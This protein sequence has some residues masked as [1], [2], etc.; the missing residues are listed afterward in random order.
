MKYLKIYLHNYFLI[1]L[2]LSVFAFFFM[3]FYQIYTFFIILFLIWY[4]YFL[5][6]KKKLTIDI[7]H[8]NY[9]IFIAISIM[10]LLASF[11][12]ILYKSFLD[13]TLYHPS[14]FC[15]TIFLFS[16]FWS[17]HRSFYSYSHSLIC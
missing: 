8:F 13:T 11:T 1:Y 15:T 3:F 14:T 9:V 17:F 4:N 10:Y 2:I 7:F 12:R 6:K 16:V 5:H